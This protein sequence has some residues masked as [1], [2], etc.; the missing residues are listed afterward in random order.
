MVAAKKKPAKKAVKKRTGG[1]TDTMSRDVVCHAF[2]LAYLRYGN[3]VRAFR[4]SV[5][6]SQANRSTAAK[7]AHKLLHDER[8]QQHIETLRQRMAAR[9]DATL[10]EW[11]SNE[12]RLAR[13]D[14]ARLFDEVGVLMP[15]AEIDPDTRHAVQSIDVEDEQVETTVN[16]KTTIV[17]R[18]RVK[19]IK[20]HSKD[21]AQDRLARYLGAYKQDNDQQNWVTTLLSKMPADQLGVLED[22]LRGCGGNAGD[23]G[24]VATGGPAAAPASGQ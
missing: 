21:G 1:R 2:A 18:T 8:T 7:E 14:P 12:L 4:E 24:Q 23:G 16:D 11:I 9:T 5:P 10:S 15:I 19:K 3:A 22:I 13:S 20:L 17:R 6:N